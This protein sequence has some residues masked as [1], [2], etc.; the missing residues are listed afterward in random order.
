MLNLIVRLLTDQVVLD[1]IQMER[2]CE[3][4]FIFTLMFL[5]DY[6]VGQSVLL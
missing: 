4:L 1:G 5:F 3:K 2:D 6:L